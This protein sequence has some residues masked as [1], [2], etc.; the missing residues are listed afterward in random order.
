MTYPVLGESFSFVLHDCVWFCQEALGDK[1]ML[2]THT[3]THTHTHTRTHTHTHTHTHAHTRAHTH[4]HTHTRSVFYRTIKLFF[5]GSGMRG[6]TTLLRRLRSLPDKE[7][8][9]TTGID[10]EDWIYPEARKFSFKQPKHPV[11]F[12]AWDF[13]GQVCLSALYSLIVS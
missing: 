2:S 6:K 9:R 3:H 8:D 5:I 12:V 10:I 13:A 1:I 4:T 7:T 11:H